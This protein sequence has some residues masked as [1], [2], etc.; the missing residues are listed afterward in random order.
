MSVLLP[1]ATLL[2][3]LQPQGLTIKENCSA[4]LLKKLP[5]KLGDH[6]RFL[7]PCDF[8]GLES[9]MALVNLGASIKLM[10]LSVWKKLSLPNLIPSRMT[11]ELATRSFAY[12]VGIAEDSFVQVGKFTFPANF[13][14]VDYDIDPRDIDSEIHKNK[15]S[16]MKSLVVEAHIVESNDLLHQLLDNDSTLP[17]EPSESSEIATLSHLPSEIRTRIT[18]DYEDSRARGF[19]RRLLKLQSLSCL[20]MGI[21][22][23]ISY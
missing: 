12:P 15:N 9:C 11:L 5:E 19:I 10:P 23:P 14:V 17:E 8:Q 3:L 1:I 7:K 18:P 20:Y 16:K 2:M 22:Y 4:V 21:R 6:G 13:I